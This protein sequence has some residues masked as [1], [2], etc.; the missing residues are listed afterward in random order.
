VVVSHDAERA[1]E[2]AAEHGVATSAASRDSAFAPDVD[3]VYISTHNEQ[4]YAAAMQAIA[5]GKHVLCEKPLALQPAEASALVVAAEEAGV[6]LAVNHHLPG[7]PLHSAVRELVGRG[8]IGTLL[9]A[10]VEHAVLLPERLRGWRLGEAPGGGVILDIT[11]H[12]ASVLNPLLGRP[13]R[14]SALATHQSTWGGRSLDAAMCVIEYEGPH[15]EPILAQ[16]HD[17]FTVGYGRT[18]LQVHGTKG[19]IIVDDAMTQDTPGTVTLRDDRGEH[20]IAVDTSHDL[21]EIVLERFREAVRGQGRPTV[22]GAE[23]ALA[24]AVALA[25]VRSAQTSCTVTV[26]PLTENQVEQ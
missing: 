25:A 18:R 14:V 7:S 17:A 24:A 1:R 2:F 26:E 8:A 3:A 13:V 12:D 16:T 11:C 23:G 22:S 20:E 6:V 21:Y 5:A 4:H 15:G 10:Q 9:S 19:T